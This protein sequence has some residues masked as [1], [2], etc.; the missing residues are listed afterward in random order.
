MARSG[1]CRGVYF[2]VAGFDSHES[3]MENSNRPETHEFAQQMAALGDGPATF[4]TLDVKA[5]ERRGGA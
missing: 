4:R 3:A 2:T 5:V 1:G